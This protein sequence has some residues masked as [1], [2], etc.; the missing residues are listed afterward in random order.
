MTIESK[1]DC[2]AFITKLKEIRSNM[3]KKTMDV[4]I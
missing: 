4:S 3:L 2:D 1:M